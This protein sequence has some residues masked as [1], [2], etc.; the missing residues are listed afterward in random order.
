MQIPLACGVLRFGETSG[1]I[2]GF[3][4]NHERQ[5]SFLPR[6]GQRFSGGGQI[7]GDRGP[8]HKYPARWER[9]V[10]IVTEAE[11]HWSHL[12]SH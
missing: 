1:E 10:T 7:D 3:P 5:D 8:A 12:T 6:G 4:K 2:F 11:I 9:Q